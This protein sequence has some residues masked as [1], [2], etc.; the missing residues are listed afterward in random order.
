MRI[1]ATATLAVM[2]IGATTARADRAPATLT[3]RLYNGSGLATDHL[4]SARRSAAAILGETGIALAFRH[5][6]TLVHGTPADACD[7]PLAPSEVVVR[8]INAP[9]ASLSLPSEAFGVTYVLEETNRGWLATVFADRVTR[10]ATRAGVEPSVL[11]GRVIAHELGHLLLGAHYHG[12]YGLMRATWS[13]AALS[14]AGESWRFSP[15]EATDMHR[16]LG[17][18]L[19]APPRPRS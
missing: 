7:Q 1:V 15:S 12:V 13:D 6:G 3:V 14:S 5:C 16:V 18:M 9:A 8:V 10:A 11:L 17:S 4:V 19:G 2:L